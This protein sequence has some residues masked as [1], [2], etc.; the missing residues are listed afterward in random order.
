MQKLLLSTASARFQR[1]AQGKYRRVFISPETL[2]DK[3][4]CDGVLSKATFY[5]HL[6]AII[7][8]EAHCISLWDGNFRTEYSSVGV[9]RARAANVPFL[10][11]SSSLPR[12]VV[13]D[14]REKL[15]LATDCK[16][17]QI[18][19]A[20]YNVSL[21]VRKLTGK[22]S[23]K[24]SLRFAIPHGA[25][26]P[27]DI[28]IQLIYCNTV[29]DTQDICEA[30][31]A[32]LKDLNISEDCVAFYNAKIGSD[33]KRHLEEQLRKGLIQILVC[34]DAVGMG[35]DMRNIFRIILW[36]LPPS[37]CALVQRSG[38]AA[39]DFSC[40]GTAV[41]I[42]PPSIFDSG[43]S[44]AVKPAAINSESTV[45]Q[46]STVTDGALDNNANDG[47]LAE[48]LT[49]APGRQLVHIP[50]GGLRVET[51]VEGAEIVEQPSAKKKGKKSMDAFAQ[52]EEER[53]KEYVNTTECRWKVWN[54]FFE[55]DRK[56]LPMCKRLP[57][58]PCCDNCD[59][60]DFPI[61]RITLTAEPG[62]KRGKK[63]KFP[64]SL[65]SSIKTA[66]V[67]WRTD[68]FADQF[69]GITTIS[70][71]TFMGNEIIDQIVDSGE[72]LETPEALRRRTHF[73][74]GPDATESLLACLR[75]VYHAWDASDTEST[76]NSSA[77]EDVSVPLSTTTNLRGNRGRGRPRGSRARAVTSGNRRGGRAPEQAGVSTLEPTPS[78][79][80]TPVSGAVVSQMPDT[81]EAMVLRRSQRSRRSALIHRFMLPQ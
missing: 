11:A 54:A 38:R 76:G 63:R 70:S 65:S 2:S 9:L 60:E 20:R 15:G 61:E 62:L 31:R 43:S 68:Y 29:N 58:R 56:G 34:T 45:N 1:I 52:L 13:N 69:G 44:A 64:D 57:G 4:F 79:E 28:P 81:A 66:L 75:E 18:S 51:V 3:A 6:R 33:T 42:V 35:C 14:I 5:K 71:T 32:W 12:H 25:V 10:I 49:I 23:T 77:V 24:S 17:I 41:L 30:L 37:F 21:Q 73:N 78:E 80:T 74:P 19:N 27:E 8:D 36:K 67:K 53:L 7:I 39:R 72:R 48:G 26:K 40:Y 16:F 55:N 47:L 22:E 46:N 59:P 50:E